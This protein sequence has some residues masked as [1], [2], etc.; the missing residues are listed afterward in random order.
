MDQIYLQ[1]A[2]L[3]N[4]ITDNMHNKIV[5]IEKNFDK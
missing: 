2:F 3:K 1:K 4:D 5:N